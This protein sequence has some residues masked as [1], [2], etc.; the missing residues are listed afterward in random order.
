MSDPVNH[1]A[2]YTHGG[3]EC[4]D[5]IEAALGREQFIGFLRGQVIKYQWRLGRKDAA[6]Q[7]NA[8]A[9]WYGNKLAE[10]LDPSCNRSLYIKINAENS[11]PVFELDQT[12]E[13][14]DR[15]RFAIPV[16]GVIC[17]FAE[18]NDGVELILKTTNNP[19]YPV[20]TAIW[21]HKSQLR[22]IDHE[23]Q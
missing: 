8:K 16:R 1:P 17:K 15:Y 3:I 6:K 13:I 10:V 4:I 20:G 9:L 12:V 11:A 18:S 7:D 2:H 14:Y 19:A 21:V 23:T 22:H 5:A